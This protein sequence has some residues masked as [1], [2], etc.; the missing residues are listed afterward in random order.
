MMA[1]A[2]SVE[3]L[4]PARNAS[5]HVNGVKGVHPFAAL[6]Y[7]LH[8]Y[9]AYDLMHIIGNIVKMLLHLLR[10]HTATHANRAVS[11][12]VLT[13]EHNRGRF[14][15][16]AVDSGPSWA[17]SL[18]DEQL[19]DLRL[20]EV[21]ASDKAAVPRNV[22]RLL[23]MQNT[24]SLMTFAFTYAHHCMSD[25]GS[26]PHTTS[27]LNMFAV[28]RLSAAD[29]F[30][31]REEH[32]SA[33]IQKFVKAAVD[34]EGLFPCSEMTYAFSQFIFA[35]SD[36]K[37]VGPPRTIWMFAFEAVHKELKALVKNKVRLYNSSTRCC[38]FLPII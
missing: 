4:G 18:A 24:H 14:L 22:F 9:M 23:G 7:F 17:F 26:L 33:R 37:E 12:K 34:L 19:V 35:L 10:R 21:C 29:S 20:R 2:R 3:A 15:N 31:I 13:Y 28:L 16:E 27:I 25:L 6:P 36:I 8:T 30:D 5:T 32:M 11:A 1:D 38:F